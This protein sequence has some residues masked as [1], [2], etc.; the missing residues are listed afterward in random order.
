MMRDELVTATKRMTYFQ[1]RVR[2]TRQPIERSVVDGHEP[3]D[4]LAHRATSRILT[5]AVR[6]D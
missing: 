3:L 1:N 5:F 2:R 4:P 6:N